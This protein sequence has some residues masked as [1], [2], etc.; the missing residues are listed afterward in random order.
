LVLDFAGLVVVGIL[1][2][3]VVESFEAVAA[4]EVVVIEEFVAAGDVV[5]VDVVVANGSVDVDVTQSLT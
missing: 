3:A 1:V 4:V 2:V 5:G